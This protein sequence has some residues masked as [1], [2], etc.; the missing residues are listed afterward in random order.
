MARRRHSSPLRRPDASG[1]LRFVTDGR[2]LVSCF[3]AKAKL[4]VARAC[5]ISEAAV[6]SWACGVARP[7]YEFALVLEQKFGVPM[8]SWARAPISNPICVETVNL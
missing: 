3:N 2:R 5:G 4:E 1:K 6:S 8:Q 7:D